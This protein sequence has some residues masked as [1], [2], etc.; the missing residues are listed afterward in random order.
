MPGIA[1]QAPAGTPE[2]G[3]RSSPVTARPGRAHR[4]SDVNRG[5]L[6][7]FSDAVLAVAITLLALNLTVPGPGH[8]PLAAQLTHQWQAFVAYLISF[9]TI[10]LIWINHHS[11]ISSVAFITRSLIFL[12]HVLLVFVVLIP[13]ATRLLVEYL[14]AG[15]SAAHFA[16]AVYGMVLEGMAISFYLELEWTLREGRTQPSFPP[17]RRWAARRRYFPGIVAYLIV[18]GSAF[19][20]PLLALGLSAA[21]IAYHVSEQAPLRVKRVARPDDARRRSRTSRGRVEVFSDAVLAVAITLLALNLTIAGPG[22]GPITDL[23]TGHWQAFVAY[24]ISFF[25]IGAIW[26]NHHSLLA[27]AVFVTRSLLFS[28]LILLVFV[29]LIPVATRLLAEY[30][31][32]G[33]PGAHLAAAVYG[34]TLEGMA[35]AFTLIFEWTLREGRTQPPV[36]PDRRW[37]ARLRYLPG[38]AAYLAVIG[39]AFIHPLLALGLSAVVDVYYGFEHAPLRAKGWLSARPH[40]AN[41]D[42]G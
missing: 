42:D 37:A 6:E 19:I 16:A 34:M 32:A 21:V 4:R 14:P 36:P 5:R 35:I 40:D 13:V 33:G 9:F 22:H 2:P 12:N 24:L 38:P 8:G 28:N 23:L 29:V 25:T 10:G 26:A 41:D 11:L 18:I 1:A 3:S 39:T 31:T 27:N 30:L 17:N 15:G 7:I 20:N